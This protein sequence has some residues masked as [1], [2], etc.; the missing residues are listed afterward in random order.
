MRG[1]AVKAALVAKGMP[2]GM[3][4]VDAP[5]AEYMPL[6]RRERT[7]ARSVS[8]RAGGPGR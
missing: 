6:F 7:H 5:F 3:L 8:A 4:I 1:E 2:L